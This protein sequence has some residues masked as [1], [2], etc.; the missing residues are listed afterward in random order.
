[1]RR[2]PLTN[3]RDDLFGLGECVFEIIEGGCTSGVCVAL[4]LG[5]ETRPAFDQRFERLARFVLRARD[6]SSV[7]ASSLRRRMRSHIARAESL[8]LGAPRRHDNLRGS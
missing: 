4:E 6:R 3:E 2:E 7:F 1:M 8:R 5:Y